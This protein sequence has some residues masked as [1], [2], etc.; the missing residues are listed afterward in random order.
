MLLCI[1]RIRPIR[2]LLL[3]LLQACWMTSVATQLGG[4]CV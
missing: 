3:L 4:G 2:L 1:P